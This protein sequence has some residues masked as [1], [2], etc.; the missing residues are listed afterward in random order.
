MKD[1]ARAMGAPLEVVPVLLSLSITCDDMIVG[2]SLSGGEYFRIAIV[3][4]T[5]PCRL[6]GGAVKKAMK[7][8]HMPIFFRDGCR[9]D[10]ND[11]VGDPNLLA[12]KQF[13]TPR[14]NSHWW[15]LTYPEQQ[16]AL[17]GRSRTKS[18]ID[19][20][21]DNES[22]ATFTAFRCVFL[23]IDE[24][25]WDDIVVRFMPLQGP[26]IVADACI[27]LEE[28]QDRFASFETRVVDPVSCSEVTVTSVS[29]YRR[30]WATDT[31]IPPF[32]IDASPDSI[33]WLT[34]H[35]EPMPWHQHERSL[36]KS[37]F[38]CFIPH[39]VPINSFGSPSLAAPTSSLLHNMHLGHQHLKKELSHFLCGNPPVLQQWPGK[40]TLQRKV[41]LWLFL[42]FVPDRD[43]H[44]SEVDWV[45]AMHH[46]IP[47]IADCAVVRKEFVR[48]GH[49]RK[50]Q[51]SSIYQVSSD[52]LRAAL[53]TLAIS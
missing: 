14:V 38:R 44:Q 30:R 47:A 19:L 52:A 7:S 17:V 46:R 5:D 51:G 8:H 22:P 53:Q 50:A 33:R 18:D 41:V 40:E 37:A 43:Y 3:N 48:H 10:L 2:T 26:P 21:H 39:S 24:C 12:V 20:S 9:L 11:L 23:V 31:F 16:R 13:V 6:L 32:R 29:G 1:Y 25:R 42:K 15:R 4:P 35:Y 28:G 27:A 45:V 36:W 49:M 34:V